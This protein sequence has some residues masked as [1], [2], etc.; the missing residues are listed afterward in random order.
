MTDLIW[1]VPGAS[2]LVLL[3]A[4]YRL[5]QSAK[6]L[7]RQTGRLDKSLKAFLEA[8]HSASLQPVKFEPTELL[9]AETNRRAFIKQRTKSKEERQRRLVKRLRD[10]KSK[11]SE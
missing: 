10:L 4:L 8:D 5:G 7:E 11:E 1:L 2:G 6:R 3:G 9:V